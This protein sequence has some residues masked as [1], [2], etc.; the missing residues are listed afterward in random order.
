MSNSPIKLLVIHC[1]A[2]K[3]SLDIGAAEI[4]TWH[5]ARGWHGIGYHYV[6]RRDGQIEYGRPH[7][8]VGAHTKG[9]NNGSLGICMVGGLDDNAEAQDNFTA[10]QYEAL[11]HLVGM[12][13]YVYP[14]VAVMGHR[15]LSPDID[16][17]GVVGPHE[18][19][20]ACPCFEVSEWYAEALG[21]GITHV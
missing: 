15:D 9:H 20:K 14:G 12:L 16:G 19:V 13:E 17:D 7:E 5:I 21:D 18:W 8:Q 10:E 2:T 4:N 6:I 1:S 3:A 11:T